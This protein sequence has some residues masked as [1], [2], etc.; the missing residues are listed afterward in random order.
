MNLNILALSLDGIDGNSD[1]VEKSSDEL[2]ESRW[3]PLTNFSGL[4]VELGSENGICD[5]SVFVNLTERKGLVHW[6]ALV[7][8]GI[9]GSLR[10]DGNADGKTS[11]NTRGGTSRLGKVISGDAWNILKLGSGLGSVK[12]G[13]S[14]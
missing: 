11:S 5:G 7:T 13:G 3:A 14:L 9:D 1:G 8:E 2:S 6:G 4:K 10:V 12:G